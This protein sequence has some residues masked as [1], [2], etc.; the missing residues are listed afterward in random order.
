MAISPNA[1]LEAPGMGRDPRARRTKA[2][3]RSLI[4]RPHQ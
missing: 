4:A 1:G 2:D 3:V